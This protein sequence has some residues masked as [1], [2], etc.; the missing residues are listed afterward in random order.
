MSALIISRDNYSYKDFQTL[1]RQPISVRLSEEVL[2]SINQSHTHLVSILKSNCSIYG[3]TTG[4]GKLSHV[5]I[6]PEDQKKLQLNLVRSH[7][8]GVG[9]PIE[10]GIVRVMMLLKLLTFSK[11]YSGVRKEIVQQ[12]IFFL[13]ENIIPVIPEKG[14]V[15]ASGDLAPLAHLALPLIGEGKVFYNG[16][17]INTEQVIKKMGIKPL[18]LEPK[19]GISLINGT[20]YSTAIAIT[21]LNQS[22]NLLKCADII[23]ALSVESSLCSRAVFNPKIH[24]L[25]CHKGQRDSAKNIWTI[26]SDSELVESHKN[27]GKIQDPY[28]FRCIPHVHG[29]SRDVITHQSKIVNNEINSVSDNPLIFSKD[30][31]YSSGHFHAEHIAQAM[32]SLGIA[33]SEIGA[34]SQKRIHYFMK[35]I[36]EI[37]P[38]FLALNPGLESGYM[39]A[40][41]TAAALASE[42]KTLSYPA[43]VDSLTTSAG[44]ED[45]VSMAPWAGQK[46][47]IIAKN[48]ATILAIELMVNI[49]ASTMFFKNIRPA[50]VSREVIKKIKPLM[51]IE[52]GD[53]PL[54]E[55]IYYVK[56]MITNGKLTKIVENIIELN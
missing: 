36:E 32:D 26:L 23:G 10:K 25:K 17:Q 8:S 40:Q 13:N 5:N 14:S 27:C 39:L 43:S 18:I 35:G 44:Q 37:I 48:T 49:T 28:S 54:D 19:E 47:E 50:S 55:E 42:N 6:N 38:P 29:A 53:R 31:I 21:L 22:F 16:K 9:K 1:I 7:A 15:G 4:F 46:A 12:L 11:G 20:Q 33:L 45:F 34:I 41:V 30:E 52:T 56:E 24:A 3:V 51:A 2:E